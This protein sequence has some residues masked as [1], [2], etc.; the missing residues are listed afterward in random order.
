MKKLN[1]VV[2][3]SIRAVVLIM[4]TISIAMLGSN[5][6]IS[7]FNSEKKLPIYC[8]DTTEKKMSITFDV[9]WG[10]DKTDEILDILDKYNAKAT[11]YVIG[12]WCDDY[13]DMVKKIHERGHEIGNHSN[14]H[15]DYTKM[16]KDAISNDVQIAN[17]KILDITGEMPKTFRFPSGAYNDAAIEVIEGIGMKAI[18]WNAD[19]IDWK[20]NGLDV[21]YNRIIKKAGPGAI[22]LFHNNAKYTAQNLE[23]ILKKYEDEGYQF[24]TVSDLI[25]QDGYYL[26]NEGK[27]IRK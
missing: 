7:V 8:V 21:E 10:N 15:P 4:L 9:N 27:Q 13:P 24:V 19:S 23:R 18:Q 16:S 1:V 26:N 2:S 3:R 6:S 22:L 12:L 14:R 20:E 25:Y 5:S 17:A 11:F